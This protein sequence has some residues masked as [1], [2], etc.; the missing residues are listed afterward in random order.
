[1]YVSGDQELIE[2]A[3][4]CIS[5]IQMYVP[6]IERCINIIR[7]EP[8]WIEQLKGHDTML[9]RQAQERTALATQQLALNSSFPQT[10][11]VLK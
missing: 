7:N 9:A 6:E 10:V 3:Q 8:D 4:E 5:I 2:M 11:I 1:M